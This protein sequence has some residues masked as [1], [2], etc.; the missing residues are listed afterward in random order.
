MNSVLKIKG[1]AL[2]IICA[3]FTISQN[4]ANIAPASAAAA[5][6]ELSHAQKLEADGQYAL[7]ASAYLAIIHG[8]D[9]IPGESKAKE[10]AKLSKDEKIIVAK[11][12]VNCLELGIKKYLKDQ[13]GNLTDCP[14]FQLLGGA[15]KDLMQLE[16][17]NPKWMYLRA[18][19]M[20][21]KGNYSQASRLL[22][23]CIAA[24]SHDES[25]KA[26]AMKSKAAIK[27]LQS[28]VAKAN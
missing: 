2:I 5:Q 26:R 19:T 4:I 15:S 22:D 24:S 10:L 18:F 11:C 21:K 27:N 8:Y 12:A 20:L 23:L 13:S 6:E 7:A 14:E 17:H 1:S 16:P 3:L 25:T 28:L 9:F